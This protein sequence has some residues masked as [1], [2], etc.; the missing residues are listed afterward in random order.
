MMLRGVLESSCQWGAVR[1]CPENVRFVDVSVSGKIVE[2]PGANLA[3][4]VTVKDSLFGGG[5][6]HARSSA[7]DVSRKLE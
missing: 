4:Q 5:R 2:S 1:V 7:S 6:R 3:L